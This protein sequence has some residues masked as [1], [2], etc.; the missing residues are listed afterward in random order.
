MFETQYGLIPAFAGTDFADGS[1]SDA[2]PVMGLQV[3]SEQSKG[4]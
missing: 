4:S 1:F 2:Q 3:L